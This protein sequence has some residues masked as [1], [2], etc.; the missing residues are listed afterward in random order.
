MIR[1]G[2][3]TSRAITMPRPQPLSMLLVAAVLCDRLLT[4]D[5]D[6]MRLSVS[7]PRT[8]PAAAGAAEAAPNSRFRVRHF[9]GVASIHGIIGAPTC[10]HVVCACVPALDLASMQ[11]RRDSVQQFSRKSTPKIVMTRQRKRCAARAR[12]ARAY[13]PGQKV[14]RDQGTLIFPL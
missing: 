11:Q 10:N 9:A 13:R 7:G 2:L 8:L 6:V 12:C 4:F 5:I 3:N 1:A 14:S